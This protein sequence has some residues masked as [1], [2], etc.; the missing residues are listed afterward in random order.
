M[1]VLNITII[2]NGKVDDKVL[3]FYTRNAMLDFM[4]K[5][6]SRDVQVSFNVKWADNVKRKGA[7]DECI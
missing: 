1:W 2:R 4:S 7:E 5:L 6:V 3:C